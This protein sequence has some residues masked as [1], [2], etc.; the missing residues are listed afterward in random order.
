MENDREIPNIL[1][2]SIYRTSEIKDMKVL[3]TGS[4][5]N[6]GE[7]VV[8][9]L[10]KQK[11]E[12]LCLDLKNPT[13]EKVAK[14]FGRKVDVIWGDITNAEQVADAVKKVDVVIHMAAM[15]PATVD[16][17]PA[18]GKKVNIGGTQN[19][20]DAIKTNNQNQQMIFCSSISVHGNNTP[21]GPHPR[22]IDD[23]FKAD[24]DYAG[25]KIECEKIID[26]S[27]VKATTMRIG[28]CMD[29]DSDIGGDPRDSL[30]LLYATHPDCRIEYVHPKDV[31]LA[32][33]NAVGNE[34]A[35]NKKFFL[36]A[37]KDGQETWYNFT[38]IIFNALGL[39]KPPRDVFGEGTFYTEWMETEEAQEVLQYQRYTLKDYQKEMSHKLRFARLAILPARPL[40]RHILL[41]QSPYK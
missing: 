29:A 25:H 18:L 39:K 1:G 40:V 38:H 36:G 8:K 28:A 14:Q 16:K 7:K 35:Y 23:P 33:V 6:I 5:G 26:A 20:I 27:G 12:V 11:H 15:L 41:S 4:F 30:Q 19:V 2:F 21:D 22:K 24:D 9:E 10:L 34:K 3:L 37:G 13:N 17:N 32:I 31:A